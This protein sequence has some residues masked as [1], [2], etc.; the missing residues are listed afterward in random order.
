[1]LTQP[2]GLLGEVNFTFSL[3]E[4]RALP[5]HN[6]YLFARTGKGSWISFGEANRTGST[7]WA[8]SWRPSELGFHAG[9]EIEYGLQP[10]DGGPPVF[11]TTGR[12]LFEPWWIGLW[13]D[14]K[15]L[16]IGVFIAGSAFSLLLL[17]IGLL[18]ALAPAHIAHIGALSFGQ[19]PLRPS[20]SFVFLA[21]L[22]NKLLQELILPLLFRHPRVKR[23]WIE[24]YLDGG[25]KFDKLNSAARRVF[26]TIRTS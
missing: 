20:T 2:S 23:A 6:V 8:A 26:L 18:L 22:G 4:S 16:L 13:R 19:E 15:K 1:M 14:N 11:L 10:D 5:A 24:K 7:E 21:A 3:L 17:G 9:D 25:A 12:F